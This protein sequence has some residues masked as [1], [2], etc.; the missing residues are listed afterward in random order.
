MDTT[1]MNRRLRRCRDYC[2]QITQQQLTPTQLAV[3]LECA[4][5]TDGQQS[6]H[7]REKT[8]ISLPNMRYIH[9]A[10][11]KMGLVTTTRLVRP[12]GGQPLLVTRLTAQGGKYLAELATTLP[13][14][15][16]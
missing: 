6:R 16:G 15:E 4:G 7:I 5:K 13:P 11:Q 2:R 1:E 3:L 10:L 9:N 14:S 12:E 8:G